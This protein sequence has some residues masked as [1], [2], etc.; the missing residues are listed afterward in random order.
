VQ[1]QQ[2]RRSGPRSHQRTGMHIALGDD[3]F[4]RCPNLEVLFEIAQGLHLRLGRFDGVLVGLRQRLRRLDVLLREDDV[5]LGDDTSCRRCGLQAFVRAAR[6]GDFSLRFGPLEFLRLGFGLRL[7]DVRLH[8]WRFQCREQL[9]VFDDASAIDV[10]LFH[11]ARHLR[12]NR[13]GEV[14]LKLAR[15]LDLTLD[16][17]TDGPNDFNRRLRRRRRRD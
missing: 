3:A 10:H 17:L 2:G 16:G 8:F 6:G 11:K 9:T 15:Q 13:H 14:R 12:E 7:E 1:S 4:K 5:V